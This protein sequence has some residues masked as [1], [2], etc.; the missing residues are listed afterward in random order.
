MKYITHLKAYMNCL[1]Y[2]ILSYIK[3]SIFNMWLIGNGNFIWFKTIADNKIHSCIKIIC[4]SEEGKL[5]RI[6]LF[7]MTNK[8]FRIRG[9]WHRF[10]EK[11]R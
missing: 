4:Y 5:S 3:L 6:S 2:I 9:N 11:S 1:A 10:E 7:R 8:N